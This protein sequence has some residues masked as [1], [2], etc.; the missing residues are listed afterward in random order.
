MMMNAQVSGVWI[1]GRCWSTGAAMDRLLVVSWSQPTHPGGRS[2]DDGRGA[3]GSVP[4]SDDRDL[5]SPRASTSALLLRAPRLDCW[6]RC[7]CAGSARRCPA[8]AAE[9]SQP[10]AADRS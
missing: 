7:R 3:S 2:R 9:L 1:I 10:V 5:H 8:P 6:V 4:H